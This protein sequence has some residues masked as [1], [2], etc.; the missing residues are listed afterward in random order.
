MLMKQEIW[1]SRQEQKNDPH[2]RAPWLSDTY[3]L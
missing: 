3:A 1:R 2:E